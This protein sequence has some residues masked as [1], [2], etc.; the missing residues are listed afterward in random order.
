MAQTLLNDKNWT[1]KDETSQ[2]GVSEGVEV[3]SLEEIDDK[4][5]KLSE[6]V[7]SPADSDRLP[8]SVPIDQVYD[9]LMLDEIRAGK[10]MA[11]VVDDELE[12]GSWAQTLDSWDP[13]LLLRL[14]GV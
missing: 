13:A 4:F 2:V 12:L 10:A 3:V 5:D 7:T 14:L 6:Q 9:L 8:S 1:P 11:I